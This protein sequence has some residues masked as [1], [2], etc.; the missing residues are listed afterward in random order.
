MA[1]E[2][3]AALLNSKPHENP[4]TVSG[5]NL[6]QFAERFL[7]VAQNIWAGV[8]Q[9]FISITGFGALG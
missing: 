7:V 6:T 5:T 9:F 4:C 2:F 1:L 3:S 8:H